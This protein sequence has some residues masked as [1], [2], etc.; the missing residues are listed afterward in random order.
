MN[1]DPSISIKVYLVGGAVRDRVLGRPVKDLDFVVV[2]ATPSDMLE[3]GFQ[4]VGADF[5]VFLHPDGNHEFAL[6]RTER[7]SGTGYQGFKVDFNK[8]IT[9]EDDLIRRDLTINSM[10]VEVGTSFLTNANQKIDYSIKDI[11]DPH[12]GLKDLR[13]GV[14]RHTSEAFAD[15]PLRVLRA[16]RFAARYDFFIESKTLSL[17]ERITKSGEM[18]ALPMERVFTEFRKALM[19]DHPIQFFKYLH[20]VC[21][22]DMYFAE[23]EDFNNTG[24][25]FASTISA[26]F[27]DRVML[28][29]MAINATDAEAMLTNLKAP[30]ALIKQVAMSCHLSRMIWEIIDRH[31]SGYN[32]LWDTFN[33]ANVWKNIELIKTTVNIQLY[34]GDYD[35]FKSVEKIMQIL[36]TGSKIGY[37]SLSEDQRNTL[38]GKEITEAISALRKKVI[39]N[40]HFT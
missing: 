28:L 35:T 3:L 13:L 32:G 26:S 7:K 9:L 36:R 16:A 11:I 31:D 19:E 10:A 29:C 1:I 23:I 17:M 38:V 8:D 40:R 14:I 34:W 25:D 15:D 12:D 6:A 27:E 39:I 2:G 22:Y 20:I 37:N 4:Q 18:K 30:S 24:L 5:P 33:R 21:A